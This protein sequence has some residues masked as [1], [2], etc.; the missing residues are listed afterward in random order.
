MS[1]IPV[2][3]WSVLSREAPQVAKFG[4]QRIDGRVSYLATISAKGLPRIHPVTPVVGAGRCFIF[5]DPKSS[6]VKDL[7]LNPQFSL[8]CGMSDSSGSSGE[9]RIS[10]RVVF[11]VDQQLRQQAESCCIYRPA[12]DYL[13]CEFK[14]AEA[15]ATTYRGGRAH[16]RRWFAEAAVDASVD[17][18]KR[19]GLNADLPTDMAS[20]V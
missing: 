5:C 3:G 15:I 4:I 7:N 6:K 9:F 2:S 20:D 17:T 12:S 1:Q 10:G 16:R 13:L 8:H 19:L 14:L 18:S 11:A